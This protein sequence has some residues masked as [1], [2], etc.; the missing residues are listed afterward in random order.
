VDEGALSA[1]PSP[2]RLPCWCG[3]VDGPE[4]GQGYR[5]CARC[6]TAVISVLPAGLHTD[7]RL[8]DGLYGKTYWLE[9][10][11]RRGFPDVRARARTDLSERCL[12]WVERLLESVRPPGRALEIGC[13][14]GA[15][16]SLLAEL[17]F[18]ASGLDVSPW[19][20][21]LARA[22]YGVSVR[23]GTLATVELEP[24][25]A[26]I[27]AFDVL[28]HL[29]DPLDAM[30]RCAPLLAPDGVL[31][32]QTPCYRGEGPDW[33][34][35][36]PDEHVYLFSEASVR[37]LLGRAGFRDVAIRPS[38]FPYDMWIAAAPGKLA[39][40]T[41]VG[42]A[43]P[44]GW[45]LPASFRALLDLKGEAEA[46]RDAL[47]EANRDRAARL[48]QVETLVDA[49]RTA[50]ADRIAQAEALL[51]QIDTLTTI[52][53]QAEAD[54]V[55]QSEA[56]IAQIDTL[57]AM[58]RKSEADR[59]AQVE[60]LTRLLGES[61]ADRQARLETIQ[62]L[63]EHAQQL[64]EHGRKLQRRLDLIERTLAWRIYRAF[65]GDM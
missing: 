4:I 23:Q 65:G 37:D 3:A 38:L 52:A 55:A 18:E 32:L 53:R 33:A 26:C 43:S 14:H 20:L 39:H 21:D 2:D 59:G 25:F 31:L 17:G 56:L 15:F 11:H 10:Q 48:E 34:M 36:Q 9:H 29:P 51:A 8:D 12:F 13:G 35:F 24:G 16:V 57:T 28:E 19:V 40:H 61:E 22:T 45:R 46:L 64:Q 6:G 60:E 30:R 62:K 54:K 47:A 42:D 49:V 5:Q 44:E 27:A 1:T 41:G 50:E 63:E 58:V 7:P